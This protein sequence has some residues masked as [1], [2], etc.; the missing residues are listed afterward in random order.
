MAK[1]KKSAK[2]IKLHAREEPDKLEALNIAQGQYMSGISANTVTFGLGPAGTGKTFCATVLAA[3]ALYQG[4]IDR[5]VV[6][7]PAVESGRGLGYLKGD[8]Q[9]KFAPYLEPIKGVLVSR[10]GK[11]W[12]ESQVK[13]ENIV[14][15]PLEF[16]Q[17]MSFDDS[18][19]LADEAENMT[20]KELYILLTRLGLRSKVVLNGDIKQAFIKNSGLMSTIRKLKGIDS[21]YVHEFDSEDVVRSDIVKSI[22]K[23]YEGYE[24]DL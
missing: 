17:G 2:S 9:E 14:P 5:I 18:F 20:E 19:I 4:S 16:M 15:V 6:T 10:F 13:N 1:V 22:I 12:Y 3:E 21:I 8:M 24:E 11:G 7:R 23:A